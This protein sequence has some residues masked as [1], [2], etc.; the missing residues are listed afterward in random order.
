MLSKTKRG[1]LTAIAITIV[2]VSAVYSKTVTSPSANAS[3]V[4]NSI[5]M[6]NSG[7]TVVVPAGDVSWGMTV[8]IPDGKQITLLGAGI[9]NTVVNASG[10]AIEMNRSGARVSGFTIVDGTIDVDGDGWRIDHVEIT[11][12]DSF[13]EGVIVFGQRTG[14][15]P[16]GVVDHCVFFNTR[17]LVMGAAAM[18]TENDSQHILWSQPLDLGSG[19]NVV[20]VEDSVFTATD[21][22]N[23][24]DANYG[25]RYVFRYN[26]LNDYY[27]E[28]H[29]VQGNN[30]AAQK[31]EI[32]NNTFNQVSNAMWVPAFIRGGTGVFF[33]NTFT[34]AW[35]TPA[36]ALDNV[37]SSEDVG[38]DAGRADGTSPW[39]GNEPG[40]FGYPARDQIG[41]STD[42]WTWSA[43]NPYPPQALDPAYAWNNTYGSD[44]DVGFFV[45]GRAGYNDIHIVEG[46]D[47][48]NGEQ[49]PGYKPY[50]Y[51]HPLTLGDA[52]G[53]PPSP[54]TNL[55]LGD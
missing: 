3:D 27:V 24:V 41:R 36:P 5:D 47:F 38:G 19:D 29:S 53:D 39:D 40:L 49:K 35:G 32:Y 20:Y 7:D 2:S 23:A 1:I 48:Y 6:A 50:T 43:S 28:V 21:F 45:H 14:E 12:A 16:T 34:G 18:L 22:G 37:R 10:T 51:P 15:H 44:T 33:N 13:G 30:R 42:Q 9:G 11:R 8:S 54:P 52:V 26:T 17:V 4:Q 31:W 55:R 25:G 46:R